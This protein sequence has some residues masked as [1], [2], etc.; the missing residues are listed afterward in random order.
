[1]SKVGSWSVTPGNNN[2]TPPDG[3][4]EGQAPSTVNDCAREMMA[5]VRTYLNDAQYVDLNNTPSFLTATTFSLGAADTTN[6]QVGRRVKLFDT[7]TLYGTINSVSATFVSVILDGGALTA[8]LSSVALAVIGET[9]NS[10]P[11]SVWRN[12]NLIINSSME[13]WQRGNSF[14]PAN[15]ATTYTT[16]RFAWV[17][18]AAAAMSIT[19]AERSAASTNVPTIL[20]SG[21]L[22]NSSLRLSVSAVDVSIANGEFAL[23]SYRVEGYDW[24]QIAHKPNV[25]SFWA[26][27]NRSGIYCVAIRNNPV[28]ASYVANYTISAINTWSRFVVTVP[29]APTTVSWNYSESTGCEISF[30]F[31]CGATYQATANAWTTMNALATSSQTNFLASAGNVYMITGVQF[32]EGIRATPLEVKQHADEVQRCQRYYW[33]GLPNFGYNFPS[34]TAGTFMSWAIPFPV[35]MRT[36]PTLAISIPGITTVN[37]VGLPIIDSPTPNGFR[38]LVG[39]SLVSVNTN[40]TF[41][42]NDFIEANGEL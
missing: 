28:S 17:Q 10:L 38:I 16:D 13:F 18:S 14:Q 27:S 21:M 35:T 41:G 34:Y 33:R 8:S 37:L 29:E 42:A 7:S 36:T 24:R 25:L 5:A 19:R 2:S 30:A 1:M 26:N 12:R 39:G 3:W 6:Y 15:N 31:A 32:E 9:T 20:Q 40:F 4:P 11:N 22:F 23:L